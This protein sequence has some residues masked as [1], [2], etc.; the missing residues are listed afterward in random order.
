MM[1]ATRALDRSLPSSFHNSLKEQQRGGV[2]PSR[3]LRKRCLSKHAVNC[4]TFLVGRE[5]AYVAKYAM[6]LRK[7][8][9]GSSLP[10]PGANPK[11]CEHMQATAQF[12]QPWAL[13]HPAGTH[14]QLR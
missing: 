1:L 7:I 11:S 5:S 4:P 13:A 2:H 8:L 9:A 6:I 14:Q 3:I 12:D 10:S